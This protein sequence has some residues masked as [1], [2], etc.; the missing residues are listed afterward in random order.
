MH[1][2]SLQMRRTTWQGEFV[3]IPNCQLVAGQT[4]TAGVATAACITFYSTS[5]RYIIECRLIHCAHTVLPGAPTESAISL[6]SFGEDVCDLLHLHSSANCRMIAKGLVRC[7][8]RRVSVRRPSNMCLCTAIVR[9]S[10]KK[11]SNTRRCSPARTQLLV[12]SEATRGTSSRTMTPWPWTK[13]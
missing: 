1:R 9:M 6:H 4:T 12:F 8:R 7:L 13:W 3:C 2:L 5:T 11:C 10:Q